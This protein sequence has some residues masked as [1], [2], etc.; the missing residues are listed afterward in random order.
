MGGPYDLDV[1]YLESDADEKSEQDMYKGIN[2]KQYNTVGKRDLTEAER[3]KLFSDE[4]VYAG[5][6]DV[7]MNNIPDRSVIRQHK[8]RKERTQKL[9]AMFTSNNEI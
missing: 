2:L 8:E 9:K 1:E 7:A 4:H 3:R 5:I 6:I